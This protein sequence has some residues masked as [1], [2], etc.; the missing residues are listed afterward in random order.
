M[1][2]CPIPLITTN[3][4]YNDV[5]E[6]LGDLVPWVEKLLVTLA[7]ANADN[8]SDESERRSQLARFV[9]LIS[10]PRSYDADPSR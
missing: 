3:Q 6:K 9:L 10:L 7:N 2:R 4:Q 8:D 1:K 5:K